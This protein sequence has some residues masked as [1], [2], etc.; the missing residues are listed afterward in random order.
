MKFFRWVTTP[1]SFLVLFGTLPVLGY[2]IVNWFDRY[3]APEQFIA[4]SCVATWHASAIDVTIYG[5]TFV[6]SLLLVI[7]PSALAPAGKKITSLVA[8]GFWV[9]ML[10]AASFFFSVLPGS[11]GIGWAVLAVPLAIGAIGGG[12][13]LLVVHS[14]VAKPV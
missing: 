6:L 9:V 14:R 3:C 5:I 13:G 10:S 1:I 4:G 8:F 7:V 11:M 12:I 2:F